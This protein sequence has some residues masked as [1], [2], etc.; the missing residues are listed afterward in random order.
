MR[1][2][3]AAAARIGLIDAAPPIAFADVKTARH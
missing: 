2:F 1:R 3:L